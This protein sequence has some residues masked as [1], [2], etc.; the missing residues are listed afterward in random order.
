MTNIFIFT[1]TFNLITSNMSRLLRF[2]IQVDKKTVWLLFILMILF[3][4]S[5]YRLT[6]RYGTERIM[7]L[8]V[9]ESIHLTLDVILILLFML[10]AGLNLGIGKGQDNG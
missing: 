8:R 4:I 7:S 3:I 5:G 10:H 2:L 6:G 9:A 1:V